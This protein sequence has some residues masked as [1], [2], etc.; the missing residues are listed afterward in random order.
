MKST[1]LTRQNS[2]RRVA[3]EGAVP[4]TQ[5]TQQHG[6]IAS[7][8]RLEEVH[9]HV[10]STRQKRLH[11]GVSILQRQWQHAHRRAH[12]VSPTNPVPESEHI[13]G[14]DAECH[15]FV[16]RGTEQQNKLVIAI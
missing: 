8:R 11:Y 14:V 1:A 15:S 3:Q 10:V 7:Q 2:L 13:L 4:H 16:N 12:R 6:Q 5:Q 9:I